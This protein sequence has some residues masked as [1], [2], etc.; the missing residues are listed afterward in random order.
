MFFVGYQALN[1][2]IKA[3]RF[4][5]PKIE[6]VIGDMAGSKIFSKPDIFSGYWQISLAK[7]V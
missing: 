6:E 1:K 3:D 4:T 2:R 7:S 5:L